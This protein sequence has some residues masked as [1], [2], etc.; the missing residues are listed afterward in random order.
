[1]THDEILKALRKSQIEL[2]HVNDF[3]TRPNKDRMNKALMEIV[4]IVY[5]VQ[6]AKRMFD[7]TGCMFRP[8]RKYTKRKGLNE[9]GKAG[10]GEDPS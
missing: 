2:N 4:H 10:T 3:L 9:T 1:V 8:T 7:K 5:S 6:E